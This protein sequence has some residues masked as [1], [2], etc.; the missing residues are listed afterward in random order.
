MDK[1]LPYAAVDGFHARIGEL[2]LPDPNDRHVLAAA[3]HSDIIVTSNLSDF[4]ANALA[5]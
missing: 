1:A 5:L 2:T 3:I 4:P